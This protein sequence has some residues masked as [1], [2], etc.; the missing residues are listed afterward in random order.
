MR[1]KDWGPANLKPPLGPLTSPW[2]PKCSAM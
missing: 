2:I 1:P